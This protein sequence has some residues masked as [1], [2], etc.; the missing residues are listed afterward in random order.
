MKFEAWQLFVAMFALIGPGLVMSGMSWERGK[1][2]EKRLDTL[3]RLLR[4]ELHRLGD[5]LEESVEKAW[6]NCPLAH[7]EQHHHKETKR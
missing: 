3:E 6:T 7:A 1:R 5:R 4:E 2:N